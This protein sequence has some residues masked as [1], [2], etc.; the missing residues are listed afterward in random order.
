[1]T[2]FNAKAIKWEAEAEAELLDLLP[3]LPSSVRL[4][5]VVSIESHDEPPSKADGISITSYIPS[6]IIRRM[7]SVTKRR[8]VHSVQVEIIAP[9]CR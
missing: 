5:K 4:T 6:L 2:A 3:R 9:V 7:E 8:V 1:V